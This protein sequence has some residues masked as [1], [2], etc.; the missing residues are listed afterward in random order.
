MADPAQPA[1]KVDTEAGP[2]GAVT[3]LTANNAVW[4]VTSDGHVTVTAFGTAVPITM[5]FTV[6]SIAAVGDSIWAVDASGSKLA[7][8]DAASRQVSPAVDVAGR[9]QSSVPA[10]S[11]APT[12]AGG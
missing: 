7:A 10:N 11:A 5:P 3:R 12:T 2:V 8:I 1:P 9:T 4:E 6:G